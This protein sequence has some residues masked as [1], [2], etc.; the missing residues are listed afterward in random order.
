MGDVGV[1]AERM[2]DVRIRAEP[3]RHVRV[4]IHRVGNVWSRSDALGGR[5]QQVFQLDRMTPRPVP[6][7]LAVTLQDRPRVGGRKGPATV[8]ALQ[9]YPNDQRL[10]TAAQDPRL[11]GELGQLLVDRL[12]PHV[13]AL[14]VRGLGQHLH[15]ASVVTT[16][17]EQQLV[18]GVGS[19]SQ[20]LPL[21]PDSA[22]GI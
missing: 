21:E 16:G 17:P 18:T 19:R 2:G 11:L 15:D 1:R 13:V 8:A 9:L 14:L 4:G 3:V 12:Q 20:L 22:L 5:G 7:P 10:V 6:S